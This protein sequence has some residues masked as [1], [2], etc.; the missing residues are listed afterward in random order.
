[1]STRRCW[2]PDSAA[3][4]SCGAVGEADVLD[5]VGH[6]RRSSRPAGRHHGRWGS[7]PTSTISVTVA[8]T[9]AESEC[10]CGT[11]PMRVCS[12][13]PLARACRTAGSRRPGAR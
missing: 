8:R 11:Y 12:G 9:D 2:P 1:M 4:S 7:R 3:T 6:G 10:R 5:G 13:K